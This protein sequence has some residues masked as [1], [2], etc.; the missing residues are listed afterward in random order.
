MNMNPNRKNVRKGE[1]Q[2]N[3][4]RGSSLLAAMTVTMNS[5]KWYLDSGATAHMT[6]DGK[7]LVN[8]CKHEEIINVTCAD[9][10][11]LP[12]EGKGDAAIRLTNDTR[13]TV[14]RDVAYILN[15]SVNLLSVSKLSERGHTTIFSPDGCYIYRNASVKIKGKFVASATE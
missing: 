9:N 15:L 2:Q 3:R 6:N 11:K 12:C 13:K 7:Y 1:E 8:Y 10:G 4:N 14:I 5:D